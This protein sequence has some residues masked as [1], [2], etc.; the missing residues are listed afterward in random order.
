VCA[1]PWYGLP[2]RYYF[3]PKHSKL[4]THSSAYPD[5]SAEHEP[6][7]V[8]LVIVEKKPAAVHI[9]KYEHQYQITLSP[10]QE[11]THPTWQK[12]MTG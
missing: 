12:Q 9:L 6:S 8:V 10:A 4:S 2:N 11:I 7:I 5:H 3:L 1:F